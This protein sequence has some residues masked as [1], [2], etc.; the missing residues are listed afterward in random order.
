MK[1]ESVN[2]SGQLF[3]TVRRRS[4]LPFFV[5]GA[6]LVAG[7]VGAGAALINNYTN[8]TARTSGGPRA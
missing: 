5:A 3:K 1:T 7:Y 6:L 8:Q 4:A 2:V